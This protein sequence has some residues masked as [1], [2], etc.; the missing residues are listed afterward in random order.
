MKPICIDLF[1]GAGGLSLG[2]ERAGFDVILANEIHPHPVC[3]YERNHPDTVVI[4]ND[5][6]K[7]SGK[8]LQAF[9][10]ERAKPQVN[11]YGID[12]LA[13][14]PP[15]QGFSTAG[16]KDATDPRNTM[17]SEFIRMVNEIKPRHFLMENVPGMMSM[18]GGAFFKKVLEMFNETGYEYRYRLLHV[19]EYGVPQMRK[20]VIFIGS[21]NGD[22][23]EFPKRTH[24]YS[25]AAGVMDRGYKKYVTVGEAISDLPKV[26]P[27][28]KVEKYTGPPES[29][30]QK[31][32]RKE[33][34][35]KL[36]NH[37]AT[38]HR[39]ETIEWMSLI[40]EGGT[41]RNLPMDSTGKR[42]ISKNVQRW[43]RNRISR[44]IT[45]E[46]TD[47]IHYM[48]DRIPTIRELAR[49]QTFPDNYVF[50]GQRTAGNQNRRFVYCSQSQQVGNSVPVIFAQAVGKAILESADMVF[51]K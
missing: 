8:Q 39:K 20:R 42:R 25:L 44:A 45:T 46:P 5:I 38:K 27:G 36:F 51:N 9:A 41:Q 10:P 30:F 1:A 28:Q 40:P 2:L 7:I 31:E 4:K 17:V 15:C 24:A 14:G 43:H 29:D 35:G 21:K 48:Y 22:A 49:I 26:E 32:M 33:N 34:V 19:D 11:K 37:E 23:P 50:L 3:T 6:R 18:H 47:F 12:L 16:L 13:G